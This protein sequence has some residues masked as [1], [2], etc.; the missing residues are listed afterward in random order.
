LLHSRSA[1]T[2]TLALT[3]ER[4]LLSMLM[5]SLS[6]AVASALVPVLALALDEASAALVSVL[7]HASEAV[8][9]IACTHD[10]HIDTP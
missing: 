10:C 9:A 7:V 6:L 4:W 5:L 8:S 1:P 3:I 2:Q